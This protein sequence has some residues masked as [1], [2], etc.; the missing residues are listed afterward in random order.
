M[1]SLNVQNGSS[2]VA[3]NNI[4]VNLGS[5][6][7][8][9]KVYVHNGTAWV[10]AWQNEITESFPFS[11]G[12]T[13][14]GS[15]KENTTRGN[16]GLIQGASPNAP[17]NTYDY[18]GL[19]IP[20]NGSETGQSIG[21]ALNGRTVKSFKV[22][23]SFSWSYTGRFNGDGYPTRASIWGTSYTSIPSS[24]SFSSFVYLGTIS[25]YPSSGDIAKG[26]AGVGEAQFGNNPPSDGTRYPQTRGD[27]DITSQLSAAAKTALT[28]GSINS[29]VLRAYTDD[30]AQ[31]YTWYSYYL[32]P[33]K[34]YTTSSVPATGD[35]NAFRVKVTHTG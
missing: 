31:G 18:H 11:A 2:W 27:I 16:N 5:W 3:A 20:G 22:T 29:F 26:W 17:Y 33:G 23:L 14:R 1:G 28:D 19:W 15:T 6:R 9:K 10:L 35:A 21:T 12:Q 25:W 32:E 13:F 8:A 4:H 30:G 24:L 7:Q 34:S